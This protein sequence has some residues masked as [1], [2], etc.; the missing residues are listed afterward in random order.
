[1]V[2]S[3]KNITSLLSL[4][5]GFFIGRQIMKIIESVKEMQVFSG[6]LRKAGKTI[7][8]VPTMGYLHE[9]HLTLMREGKKRGNC[10]V[11]SIYVN[12]TQFGAGD[13]FDRYPKDMDRDSR[14]AESAG[15]DLIFCPASSDMYP[16]HYQTF[17]DLEEVTQNLCGLTRQGYFRGVATVCCKLFNIVNPHVAIFGEK[18]FQQLAVIRRMVSDLNMDIEIIGIP[19]VREADG[20]AMSS[21]NSYLQEKERE[22]ALV[23]SRSLLLAKRLY[24][25]GKRNVADILLPVKEMLE[26]NSLVNLEYAKI[27]DVET[28][29]D[30]QRLEKKAVLAVAARV[31]ATRLIDNYVFEVT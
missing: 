15:V 30:L 18:D 12:P 24:D 8:F 19:T 9:G 28:L 5:G 7:S 17:I 31:G 1:V 3:I 6:S 11:V 10:S 2:I 22:A 14:M 25:D 27:C 29:K 23:L 21:R 20:L 4:T 26:G 16:E 13:D